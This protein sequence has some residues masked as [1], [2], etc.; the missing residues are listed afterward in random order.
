VAANAAP[1][2]SNNGGDS[3]ARTL[4]KCYPLKKCKIDWTAGEI[5]SLTDVMEQ[6]FLSGEGTERMDYSSIDNDEMLDDHWSREAD[7]DAEKY[8][9]ED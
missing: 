1:M 7:C 6:K 3:A 8:F 5:Q 2:D 9:E 4:A